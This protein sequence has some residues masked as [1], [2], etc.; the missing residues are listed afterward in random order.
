[1]RVIL[2]SLFLLPGAA[3]ADEMCDELLQ[4]EREF[5]AETPRTIDEFTELTLVKVNGETRVVSYQKRLLVPGIAAPPG[6]G[7]QAP[8]PSLW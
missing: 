4:A 1:M 3:K 2:L 6:A 8:P 7:L 5:N